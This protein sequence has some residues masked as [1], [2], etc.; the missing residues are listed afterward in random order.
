MG[1]IGTFYF[2]AAHPGMFRAIAPAGAAP[3]IS[4]FDTSNL[5]GVPIFFTA[6]TKD[7]HGFVHMETAF[8]SM[9]AQDLT[10]TFAPIEG[11]YHSTAWV[12]NLEEWIAFLLKHI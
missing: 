7:H 2:A 1:G 3:D 6:G 4:R 9:Q 11:G 8:Y 10:I 12:E 5:H